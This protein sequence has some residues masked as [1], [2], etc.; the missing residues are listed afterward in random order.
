MNAIARQKWLLFSNALERLKEALDL[1]G[2][3]DF[4]LDVAVKRFE[5]CFS[6]CWKT[7]KFALHFT[8]D[9]I[10]LEVPGEILKYCSE[11]GLVPDRELARQMLE[12]RNRAAYIYDYDKAID[13][14]ERI[15]LYYE[16]MCEIR[17]RLS[18]V[19]CDEERE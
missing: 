19:L 5:F 16:L 1:K 14:A 3:N 17:D 7:L 15:P 9:H 11:N 18:V 12:D 8:G 2:K 13:I 10:R 6:L 4:W